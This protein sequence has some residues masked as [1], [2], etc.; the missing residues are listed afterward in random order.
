MA[1][2]FIDTAS[3]LTG[4]GAS[5]GSSGIDITLIITILVLI[6]LFGL[7]AGAAT[8]F[9]LNSRQWRIK[10]VA[11]ET[12]NKRLQPNRKDKAKRLKIQKT[13]DEVLLLKKHKKILPFPVSQTGINSYWFEIRGDGEWINIEPKSVDQSENRMEMNSLEKDMRY[14][15]ASL[16]HLS[17]E[18][19]DETSF[20]QKYGGLIAYSVLIICTAIGFWLLIDQM[21]EVAKASAQAVDASKDVLVEVKKVLGALDNLKG[22]SGIKQ[23]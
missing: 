7:I 23:L 13:G 3:G 12:I 21:I 8:F 14:A 11:F 19:Y 6:V 18:R 20:L 9:I 5:S 16:A 4:I 22:G 2:G 15:R 10:I 17:K 1:S